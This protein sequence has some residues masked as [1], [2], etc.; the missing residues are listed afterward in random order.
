MR[1]TTIF[2]DVDDTLY[3]ASS[4]LWQT[5]RERITIYMRERLHIPKEDVSALRKKLYEQYGTTLKGLEQHYTFD[6]KDFLAFVH[7]V[8]LKKYIQPDENLR[9]VL[10]SLPTKKIIFTNADE[11]HAKRITAALGVGDCFDGIVDTNRLFPHC[12]PERPAFE[13]AMSVAG[14]TNPRQCVMIDDL[15]WTTKAAR[16]LGMFSILAGHKDHGNNADAVL[17][18][19]RELKSVISNQ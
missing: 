1:F 10:K 2:F 6:R 4:G 18:D 12:K 7:D 8:D 15:A 5:I 14:E 16:E 9:A 11:A 3:P 13:F 19:W 17:N